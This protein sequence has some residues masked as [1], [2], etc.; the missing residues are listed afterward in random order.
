MTGAIVRKGRQFLSIFLF[1]NFFY[2][3]LLFYF[4][5]VA[6]YQHGGQEE[7]VTDAIVRSG[8]QSIKTCSAD[9]SKNHH[10]LSLQNLPKIV[11]IKL[12]SSQAS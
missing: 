8:R 7:A 6:D 10:N 12:T 1:F 9:F 2:L 4:H 3:I 5:F 11:A